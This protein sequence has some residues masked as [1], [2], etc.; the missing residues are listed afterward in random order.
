MQAGE[1]SVAQRSWASPWTLLPDAWPETAFHN[2]NTHV[3]V[4]AGGGHLA[5]MGI[6]P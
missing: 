1:E 2:A 3:F 5:A 6:S 4:H